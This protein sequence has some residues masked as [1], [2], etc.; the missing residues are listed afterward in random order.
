MRFS[1]E[2]NLDR[3]FMDFEVK[4]LRPTFAYQKRNTMAPEGIV[5]RCRTI[6]LISSTLS[7]QVL[8]A[9]FALTER[10]QLIEIPSTKCEKSTR[11]RFQSR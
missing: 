8:K 11:H 10:H 4:G 3:S 5:R 1:I 9:T 7:F 6:R 2:M